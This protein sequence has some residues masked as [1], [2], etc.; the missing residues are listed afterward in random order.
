[1]AFSVATA[2][3]DITPTLSTNPYM[4]G[5][6][7]VDGGRIATSSTPYQPLYARA[8]VLWEDTSHLILSADLLAFPRPLFHSR[9]YR[10][11]C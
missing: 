2:K 9:P 6:G 7:T 4:A 8:I 5:Y 3:V 1:M 10:D 11:W